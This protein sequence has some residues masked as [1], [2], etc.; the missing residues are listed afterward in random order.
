M[1]VECYEDVDGYGWGGGRGLLRGRGGVVGG[2]GVGGAEGG[3][4]DRG[5]GG[6]GPGGGHA[7]G[8][9]GS[10]QHEDVGGGAD[11][12]C[13]GGGGEFAGADGAEVLGVA[14]LGRGGVSGC[15]TSLEG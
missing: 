15:R 5:D 7:V 4:E 3:T 1:G 8:E 12:Q 13:K 10:V 11:A 6:R 14:W 2:G 9:V